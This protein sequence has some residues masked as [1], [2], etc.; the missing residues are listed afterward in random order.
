MYY[1]RNRKKKKTLFQTQA[2]SIK[3]L[4]IG[5][6][7]GV[8]A[9]GQASWDESLG[10]SGVPAKQLRNVTNI[11]KPLGPEPLQLCRL[12]QCDAPGRF[13]E[14][15]EPSWAR[16]AEVLVTVPTMFPRCMFLCPE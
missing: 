7:E 15:S 8:F 10:H 2:L 6:F 11:D 16:D 5:C 12:D 1:G 13:G 3:H 4:V 9:M 14:E